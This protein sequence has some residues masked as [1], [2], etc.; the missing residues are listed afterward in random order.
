MTPDLK[1]LLAILAIAFLSM[2]LYGMSG[3]ARRPD[4]LESAA[5]GPFLLGGFL[6]SWF[7]WSVR[8]LE[9]ASL[10]L[11]IGPLLYNLL[12]AALGIAAG[13]AFGSGHVVLGGWGVLLGGVADVMDGRIARARC[14][15]RLHP[16]SLRRSGSVH[17]LGCALPIFDP[18]P[19]LGG[20]GDGRVVAGELR[21]CSWG[22][23]GHTV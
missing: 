21:T 1:V 14:L 3:R 18:R 17:R 10:A 6:K 11:G 12:G 23:S 15:P 16:R 4:P 5:R 7:L 2:P 13:F 9:R 22:E 20:D 8:P 19:G